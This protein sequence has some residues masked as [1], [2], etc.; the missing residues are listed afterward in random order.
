MRRA[1]R[2]GGVELGDDGIASLLDG[3]DQHHLVVLVRGLDH[4][5]GVVVVVGRDDESRGD[6]RDGQHSYGGDGYDPLAD[7]RRQDREH[8]EETSLR[9]G[10]S[11]GMNAP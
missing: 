9:I 4:R 2:F 6:S 7:P 1:G 5:D 3:A 10:S 8:Y 11:G